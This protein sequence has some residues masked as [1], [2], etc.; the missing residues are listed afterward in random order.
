MK[1]ARHPSPIDRT[2]MKRVV[3]RLRPPAERRG[4]PTAMGSA[5]RRL[6]G[7]DEDEVVNYHPVTEWIDVDER[8]Q[9][10]L[11]DHP[12][13]DEKGVI[14]TDTLGGKQILKERRSTA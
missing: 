3:L 10:P 4:R 12:D 6:P 11:I 8:S 2:T 1:C 14:Q 13:V 5:I 7:V 9:A